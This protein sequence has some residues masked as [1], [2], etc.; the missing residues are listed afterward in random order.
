MQIKLFFL[1]SCL[2]LWGASPKCLYLESPGYIGGAGMFH[3]FNIVLGC[4]ELY[5]LHPYLSLEINFKDKGLYYNSSYGPNWWSYYF[6]NSF[7]PPREHCYKRAAI[8]ILKDH[9]KAELG[10]NM[11]FYAPREKA[12]KLIDKYIRVKQDILGEVEDFATR[13]FRASCM[14]GVHYRGSDKWLEANDVSYA[15]AIEAIK[16]EIAKYDDSKIFVATDESDFLEAM[17]EAFGDKVLY[18]ASQRRYDHLPLHYFTSDG[19]LQGKEALIDCLL[20]SKCQVLIRTN[21]NLSAVSAFFNP[22]LKIINLNTLRSPLYQ[23]VCQKGSLNEL[24]LFTSPP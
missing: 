5:D 7:Y 1:L 4:L 24:N 20:L 2:S 15:L 12:G 16:H 18:T 9:E 10:N 17:Q 14:I 8:K 13:Y 22:Y 11:H 6:E 3:N 19:Y 23:G 21:S